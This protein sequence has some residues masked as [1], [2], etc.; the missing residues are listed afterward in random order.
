M[1]KRCFSGKIELRNALSAQGP[2]N[3]TLLAAVGAIF[4]SFHDPFA[5]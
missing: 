3:E 1:D 5:D 4:A 2:Q